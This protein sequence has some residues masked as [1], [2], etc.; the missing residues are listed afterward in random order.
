MANCIQIHTGCAWLSPRHSGGDHC[1]GVVY[2]PVYFLKFPRDLVREL[3]PT[4]L[5]SLASVL[6]E[7]LNHD[8]CCNAIDGYIEYTEVSTITQ[9]LRTSVDEL[10]KTS[11]NGQRPI[12]QHPVTCVD[13]QH[14][15]EAAK[16][17]FGEDTLWT[18]R[19]LCRPDVPL[20]IVLRD[21]ATSR[22]LNRHSQQ[23]RYSD[24]EVFRKVCRLRKEGNTT[25]T[26]EWM[27]GLGEQKKIN[28]EKIRENSKI[29]SSLEELIPFPGIL[30]GLPL[31]S[32][33]KHLA[34]H[35]DDEIVNYLKRIRDVWLDISCN[36]PAV[37][38]IATVQLL[39]GRAPRLSRSDRRTVKEAFESNKVFTRVQD[40]PLRGEIRQS[41]L[42]FRGIIPSLK[43]FH[44]N[45]KY[46]SIGVTVVLNLMYPGSARG[47]SW[48]REK[49][50]ER[51]NRWTLQSM[52]RRSWSQPQQNLI[53][54]SEGVFVQCTEAPSFKAAYT[55]VVLSALRNYSCLDPATVSTFY[56]RAGILGFQTP[57]VKIT[58][59]P[60][61]YTPAEDSLTATLR[62]MKD[63]MFL[64]QLAGFEENGDIS[65]HLAQKEFL[66][67]FFGACDEYHIGSETLSIGT[68]SMDFDKDTAVQYAEESSTNTE[69]NTVHRDSCVSMET[70]A[71]SSVHIQTVK[72]QCAVEVSRSPSVM[73]LSATINPLSCQG[74]V[75]EWLDLNASSTTQTIHPSSLISESRYH[76]HRVAQSWS[77]SR[78]GGYND[79]PAQRALQSLNFA[80]SQ[81]PTLTLDSHDPTA[82][83]SALAPILPSVPTLE[84]API[85]GPALGPLAIYST[86][87]KHTGSDRSSVSST[88]VSRSEIAQQD[89][90]LPE[91]EPNWF[92]RHLP[93]LRSYMPQLKWALE[94]PTQ[95]RTYETG[96]SINSFKSTTPYSNV[97]LTPASDCSRS[98]IGFKSSRSRPQ[99]V[100]V[101]LQP[102]IK[103]LSNSLLKSTSGRDWEFQTLKELAG[104]WIVGTQIDTNVN[105]AHWFL[106]H[107]ASRYGLPTSSVIS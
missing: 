38:D 13:G 6:Q 87:P 77:Q 82:T 1:I 81:K 84:A 39:E 53:E 92:H 83:S 51:Q 10:R 56:E 93:P 78:S 99:K 90:N 59:L 94:P 89:A 26:Y 58:S 91:D 14:R 33:H 32:F 21:N 54:T 20:S 107:R 60:N 7:D 100:K 61:R 80:S 29:Y 4:I 66:L 22:K 37:V 27:N 76:Q 36:H 3:N 85:P 63:F 52:L 98:V 97:S 64:P 105:K 9:K 17:A 104:S 8:T 69:S 44:E 50:Y 101:I 102:I 43:S 31:G 88:A 12:L 15:K 75:D 46:V 28:I 55:Q 11:I 16:M 79:T 86:L 34:L 30:D 49:T 71:L 40:T 73:S 25:E 96:N 18:V 23:A 24:G 2:I 41:I 35:C 45:M 67:S 95:T 74:S 65:V 5:A 106:N 70:G 103:I 57:A 42:R 19:L 47:K 68:G 62:S 48:K 72:A